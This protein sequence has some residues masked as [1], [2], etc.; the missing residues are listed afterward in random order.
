M[1]CGLKQEPDEV[2]VGMNLQLPV[3][4]QLDDGCPSFDRDVLCFENG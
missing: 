2:D 1:L 4:Y 3:L